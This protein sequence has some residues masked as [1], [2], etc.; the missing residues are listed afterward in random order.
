VAGDPW[1][2]HDLDSRQLFH[3]AVSQERHDFRFTEYFALILSFNRRERFLRMDF[4]GAA[5]IRWAL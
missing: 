3:R 1:S 4:L 2:E 5:L